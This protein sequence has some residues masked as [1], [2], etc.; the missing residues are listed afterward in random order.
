MIKLLFLILCSTLLT[1]TGCSDNS[2]PAGPPLPQISEEDLEGE[3]YGI[4]AGLKVKYQDES[5]T[6]IDTLE[7]DISILGCCLKFEL[8]AEF[9]LELDYSDLDFV[10]TLRLYGEWALDCGET[11]KVYFLPWVNSWERLEY[12]VSEPKVAIPLAMGNP[13]TRFWYCDI[14]FK[15]DTLRLYNIGGDW[16]CGE[17]KLWEQWNRLPNN[18][19]DPQAERLLSQY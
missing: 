14:E 4:L 12:S 15:A 16:S 10:Y 19:N 8:P 2:N 5:E 1:I 7:K 17:M 6:K 11:C 9:S 3:W 18:Q 13:T